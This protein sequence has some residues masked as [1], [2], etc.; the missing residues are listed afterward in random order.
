MGSTLRKSH[1]E[2][3]IKQGRTLRKTGEVTHFKA[4]TEGSST[5]RRS[6]FPSSFIYF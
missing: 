3:N 1:S 5:L 4:A 6:E 2:I